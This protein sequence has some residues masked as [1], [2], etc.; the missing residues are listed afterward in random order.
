M[1]LTF[2]GAARQVT[3]SMHLITL[4][5]GY[6]VL[7]D[8][9]LQYE[10][11]EPIELNENFPFEPA[12]IDLLILT[13]AHI[14]HS[15]NIPTLVKKGYKGQ[16]ICTEPTAA[17]VENLLNDSVNVQLAESKARKRNYKGGIQQQRSLYGQK[18][19][20]NT[21]DRIVTLGFKKQFKINA[22]LRMTFYPAGHI[23]GAASV[24]LEVIENGIM[25]RIGFTGDLGNENSKIV[26][27]AEPMSNLDYLVSEST[28][29]NRLHSATLSAEDELY[30]HV[31]K[32]CIDAPGR[33]VIPAFSVGRTQAILFT[34]N[35]LYTQGKLKGITVFT[36]S[37][38]GILSTRVHEKYDDYLNKETKDFYKQYGDLF[39]FPNLRII[40]T[41]SDQKEL[42]YHN[43][44][45]I[46]VSSAGMIEGGR[47]QQHVR[48]NIQNPL[49]TILIA[50]YCAEGT[51]GHRLLLGQPTI[52]IR[53]KESAVYARIMATDVF[54]AHPDRDGLVKYLKES[55][56]SSLKKV[57]LVHGEE[58]SM[59]AF[60]QY[61]K[62]IGLDKITIP[63]RGDSVEL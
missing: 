40:Q 50:G 54:S 56:C 12:E 44:P 34:L 63:T 47:I 6:K 51:L 5:S 22:E 62:D 59:L 27:D 9:G 46:I 28:Y 36:D 17:L 37:T 25:K 52:K 20:L 53:N 49:C 48:N 4:Q 19:V 60:G 58:K 18:D 11:G 15:G 39:D 57:F 10:R 24:L 38:L 32:N 33:L 26:V 3:G 31:K 35:Q 45:S 7:I 21:I 13:H 2:W 55:D 61:L 30:K 1:N 14:D 29:G 43:G 42:T 41:E 16:V 8:C 23:L